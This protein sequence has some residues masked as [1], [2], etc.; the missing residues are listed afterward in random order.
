VH[1]S[2]AILGLAQQKQSVRS[3]V[4]AFNLTAAEW[5][6]MGWA[7]PIGFAIDQNQPRFVRFLFTLAT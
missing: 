5:E 4:A 3:L 6:R 2:D 7:S 1:S